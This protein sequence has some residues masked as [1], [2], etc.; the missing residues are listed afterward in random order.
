[1]STY[2]EVLAPQYHSY[3]PPRSMSSASASALNPTKSKAEGS[4][5]QIPLLLPIWEEARA[6]QEALNE[7]GSGRTKRDG[8]ERRARRGTLGARTAEGLC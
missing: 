2:L 5:A 6:E 1:M 4:W 7:S 8:E 3:M